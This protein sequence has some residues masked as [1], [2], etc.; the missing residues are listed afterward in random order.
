MHDSDEK[1][2]VIQ[3]SY[4]DE[5]DARLLNGRVLKSFTNRKKLEPM[6]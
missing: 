6:K 3:I 4:N 1:E 2:T 5:D